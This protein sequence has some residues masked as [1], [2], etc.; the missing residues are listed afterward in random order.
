[1]SENQDEPPL[2]P[3]QSSLYN[4]LECVCH[5]RRKPSDKS[6]RLVKHNVGREFIT[7]GAFGMR[8]RL[9]MLPILSLHGSSGVPN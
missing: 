7:L 4:R 5:N 1:M 9:G 3:E 2:R 8:H 6:L